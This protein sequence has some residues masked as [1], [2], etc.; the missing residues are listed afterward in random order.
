MIMDYYGLKMLIDLEILQI[1]KIKFF[2][3]N[4]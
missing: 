2:L 4:I 1:K 3:I